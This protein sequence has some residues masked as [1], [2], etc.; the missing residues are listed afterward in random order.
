[1]VGKKADLH[2]RTTATTGRVRP[3]EAVKLA[4]EM[5]LAAIA[6]VDHDTVEGV[7]E[8]VEAGK[9][10]GV[11]VI[12]GVEITFEEEGVEA[13]IIGYFIDW[14]H[15]ALL[16]EISRSQVSR[17]WR[18]K[19]TIEKL[20]EMGVRITYN[21]VVKI[22]GDA[23]VM[24]RTHIAEALVKSGA[25]KSIG[26]AFSRYLA[27]R[28][29][30][31]VPK[32]QLPVGELIGLVT[33]AGGVT[34]LAHPKFGGAESILPELVK[35]GLAGLEVYHPYHEPAD[36]R[37]FQGLAKKYGLVEVGGTDSEAKRSPVGTITVPYKAVESLKSEKTM[38][39]KLKKLLK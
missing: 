10:Y 33:R 37:K 4:K 18:I 29:P 13:H 12:P 27:P 3:S 31:Y 34:A 14:R 16:S 11:E 8:A 9:A 39:K 20:Q 38:P 2:V 24:G 23:A 19:G 6:I 32:Y 35:S 15:P 17:A 28:K 21:D 7:P 5:G 30:A 25:V 26:E 22:A 36:V 1:M